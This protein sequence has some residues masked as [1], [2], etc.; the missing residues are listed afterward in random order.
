MNYKD[1]EFYNSER[2]ELILG[3]HL[4]PLDC[5]FQ[6]VLRELYLYIIRQIQRLRVVKVMII[7]IMIL[8]TII[9]YSY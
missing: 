4:D 5:R 7:V 2:R 9:M 1:G 8:T 3:V 6:I